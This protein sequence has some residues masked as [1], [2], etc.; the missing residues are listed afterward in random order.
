MELREQIYGILEDIN[1]YDAFT[2]KELLEKADQI[3]ALL[4]SEGYGKMVLQDNEGV[5][6]DTEYF[7]PIAEVKP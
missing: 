6:P 4:A 3:L 5:V 7:Q 2:R 1:L